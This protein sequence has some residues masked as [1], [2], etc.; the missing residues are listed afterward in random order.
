[1][2]STERQQHASRCTLCPAGCALALTRSGPDTW[3][4]EYPLTGG[5]GLCPRGGA[6]GELVGHQLRIVAPATRHDGRLRPTAM[7]SA[8]GDVLDAADEGLTVMLDG[9][10]PAEQIIS[11]AG[12]RRR[13]PGLKVC[14][15]LEPAEEQ[16]LLGTEASGAAYL[17]S[18]DLAGCD[19]FVIVGD[20][21]AA[22]PV[23]SRGVFDRRRAEPR[24]PIVVIDPGAGTSS[25]FASHCPAVAPGGE[26]TAVAQLASSMGVDVTSV[27]PSEPADAS[28]AAAGVAVAGCKRLGVILAAEHGRG[29]AWRQIGYLAGRL[30]I[31]AGGGVAV[32]TS[33]AN[34]LAAVRLA[35]RCGLVPLA[36]AVEGHD[37]VR[38]TIGCDPIGMLGRPDVQVLAAAAA[39][40]NVTTD[41]A[42]I[43]LPVAMT[44]EYAGTYLLDGAKRTW[45]APVLAPPAGVPTADDLIGALA[46]A[47]G[48]RPEPVELTE[49]DLAR[50]DVSPPPFAAEPPVPTGVTLLL[51]RCGDHAGSGAL[52]GHAAWQAAVQPIPELRIAPDD[53]RRAGIENFAT[54]TVRAGRRSLR[55]AARVTP[56]VP[57]GV[58]VLPEGFAQTRA[59]L[60][61]RVDVD[62]GAVVAEPATVD[63][64]A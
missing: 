55:A 46:L 6:I 28:V 64:S 17:C 37:E 14:L 61:G 2:V 9:N 29:A 31:A 7:S 42:S 4:T 38:I 11:V 19:G 50:L 23:C 63:V 22:N 35:R 5:A 51:G 62:S 30:A 10:V 40:P 59:L 20:A 48:I 24:T 21:F 56:D 26:L 1:M 45:V 60:A 16:L 34:A 41:A 43:V 32:Q 53:A 18:A 49:A 12:W 52:T 13:W 57:D 39:L 33:S 44:C 15:V 27:A 8:I 3:R 58:V 47:S 25:K 36:E 54:V